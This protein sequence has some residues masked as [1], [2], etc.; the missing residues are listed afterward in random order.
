MDISKFLR[1][2]LDYIKGF[3]EIASIQT[4]RY[5]F[6]VEKFDITYQSVSMK[7]KVNYTPVGCYRPL[8]NLASELNDE[9]IC[10]KFK[11]DHARMIIGIDTLEKTLDFNCKEQTQVYLTFV[12]SCMS[13]LKDN[14]GTKRR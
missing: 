10:R 2:I 13:R 14:P 4:P 9:M 7:T 8:K 5:C 6:V 3:L 11:P 12:K 1:S